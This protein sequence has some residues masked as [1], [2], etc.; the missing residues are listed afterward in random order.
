M[1]LGP[2][3]LP[4]AYISANSAE[5]WR[6]DGTEAGTFPVGSLGYGCRVQITP[7]GD[8]LFFAAVRGSAGCGLWKTDA[9]GTPASTVS[10]SVSSPSDL[11]SF[12]GAL[13]FTAPGPAGGS[14]WEKD[15]TPPRTRVVRG[16]S[17][18]N[19]L[20][21]FVLMRGVGESL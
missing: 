13:Y 20:P 18:E 5:M 12:G 16:L 1:G 6:S 9:A 10:D 4:T 21:Q 17:R 19:A 15:G 8:A 2:C 7:V 14:L 3:V 11:V